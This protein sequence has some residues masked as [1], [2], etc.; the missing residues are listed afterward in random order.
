LYEEEERSE[1]SRRR[2]FERT[3]RAQ[4][5]KNARRFLRL[6]SMGTGVW[7]AAVVGLSVAGI[8]KAPP[9]EWALVGLVFAAALATQLAAERWDFVLRNAWFTLAIIDMPGIFFAQAVSIAH[10]DLLAARSN[11]VFTVGVYAMAI[12]IS[13]LS[14]RKSNVI[15][16][17]LSGIV[18]QIA[19]LHLVGNAAVGGP[20]VVLVL[21]VT[22]TACWA[23]IDQSTGLIT[24]TV[25]EQA[26]SARLG[27]YFSPGVR[28]R[29]LEQGRGRTGEHREVTVLFADIR[30]FT[31]MSEKMESPAVVALLNEY[32]EQ[33]VQVIFRA[34]G[35]LDKFIGDGIMAYFGAPLDNKRHAETAVRCA[36]EM[37]EALDKLNARRADRGDEPLRIGIGLHTGRVVVGT[38]GPPLRREYTAIGDAVNT[39]S[40]IEGLTKEHG[41]SVLASQSTRQHAGDAFAWTAAPPMEIRGKRESIAT[42]IPSARG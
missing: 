5:D 30:G 9:L 25:F 15:A 28:D 23:L 42:W 32:L 8:G 10:G 39:A 33:M 18:L 22:G 31:A 29:I 27:Q 19:L 34:N 17:T 38:I 35:T 26:Q 16:A 37:L 40:R 21:G 12:A 6:R 41:V 4:R 36:L 3:F 11:G 24:S 14:M 13:C 7:F 1:A 2:S 20:Y